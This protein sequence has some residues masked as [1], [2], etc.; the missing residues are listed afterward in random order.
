MINP[1]GVLVHPKKMTTPYSMLDELR[2]IGDN[3]ANFVHRIDKETSGLL[4]ATLNRSAESFLKGAF[5]AKN[6]EKSYRAWVEGKIENSFT[7]KKPILLNSDYSST[8][9]KVFTDKRGKEAITEF[10][11][12]LYNK[13]K[14]TT[15]L[16][17]TPLTGR[18][19]Q[20]R[21]HLYSIGHPIIGEPL[22]G[23]EYKVA[24][25][26]LENRLSK[27][28]RDFYCGAERLMLHAYSLNFEYKNR[29]V[30]KSRNHFL[31]EINKISIFREKRV[32]GVKC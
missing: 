29:F 19:H 31:K 15:L 11:P 1:T 3:S 22:Y 4:L 32:F 21:V 26:Y 8:K 13:E 16:K 2:A 5:E 14:D 23:R 17:C 20:I 18:T 12:I 7:V 28:D 24:E 6:I 27:E 25:A 9:H 30:I 10:S